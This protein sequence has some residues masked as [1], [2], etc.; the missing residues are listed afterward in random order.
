VRIGFMN[1]PSS[2]ASNALAH[3]K[4]TRKRES[5]KRLGHLFLLLWSVS[6]E[7]RCK[8]GGGY[9]MPAKSFSAWFFSEFAN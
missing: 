3:V 2:G 1:A 5:K 8:R 7:R 9:R 6:Q 4:R